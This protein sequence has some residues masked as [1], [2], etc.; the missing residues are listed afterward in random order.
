MTNDTLPAWATVAD[1]VVVVDTA[2]AYDEVKA[3]LGW[4]AW[5][6]ATLETARRCVIKRLKE[7]V[8]A[9]L[10]LMNLVGDVGL[11]VRLTNSPPHRLR[12]HP[13]GKGAE[14]GASQAALAQSFQ[15]YMNALAA[16]AKA[17]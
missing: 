7:T 14:Y 11:R 5:D 10:A 16:K 9:S 17:N 15:P 2:A 3:A 8:G 6:Q 12:D 4:G 1:G 13:Q